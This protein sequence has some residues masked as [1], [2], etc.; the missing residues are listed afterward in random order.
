MPLN[1]EEF[2]RKLLFARQ[3][4]ISE[5]HMEIYG[6]PYVFFPAESFTILID[7]IIEV[8]GKEGKLKIYNEG[9]HV[10]GSIAKTLKNSLDARGNRLLDVIF[11]IG[12]MGGWGLWEFFRKDDEKKEAIVH[13]LN[14]AAAQAAYKLGKR[15]E[16]SCHMLRGI[17]AGEMRE[18]WENKNIDVLETRCISQ[19]YKFCEF[20]IKEHKKFNK[21]D[22][23]VKEE[24]G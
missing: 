2:F 10:G 17:M 13:G 7:S 1:L 6:V 19:G 23:L 3:L 4:K 16:P 12:G 14:I 21:K 8:A 18:V 9:I 20:E 22:K 15:K 24:L 11:H 5:G